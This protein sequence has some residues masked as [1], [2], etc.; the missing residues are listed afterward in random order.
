M[1]NQLMNTMRAQAA[2]ASSGRASVRL[3]IVSSY[4]HANYCA[5]VRVQPEDTETGWLPVTSPWIGN[6][7]GMFAP[8]TP[9]DLVEVQFQEDSFEAGF[10]CQRFFNDADRPLPV[11]SG[12]FWLVHKSGSF[13]KFRNDGSVELNTAGNLTGTVGGNAS[14]TVAGNMTTNV[15]GNISETA[16]NITLNGNVMINGQLTQG[17]GSAGGAATMQGP[18]A[19]INDVTAAG[20][21]LDHHVHSGV[22]T[23][24]GN[25]GQ[26]V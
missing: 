9:G 14:L 5:K 16:P 4:D 2:L 18:L 17:T 13:L 12:E 25:T 23:G 15:S 19:V 8:P 6:G 10:V 26:P 21:S 3:G 24:G 7:W 20:K 22:Q 11:P 1:M